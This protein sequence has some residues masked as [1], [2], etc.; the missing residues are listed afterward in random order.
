MNHSQ[1]TA[2]LA[3][4]I[5]DNRRLISGL[6]NALD[7]NYTRVLE[8]A[9]NQWERHFA[10]GDPSD[11]CV[12]VRISSGKPTAAVIRKPKATLLYGTRRS[13]A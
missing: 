3:D 2:E 7:V 11:A 10:D 8:S 4:S 12:S 1:P 6:R 9:R 13:L 5:I